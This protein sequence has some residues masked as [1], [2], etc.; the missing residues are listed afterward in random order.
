MRAKESDGSP[1]AIL[2]VYVYSTLKTYA[3]DDE[4]ELIIREV[5]TGKV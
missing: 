4:K 3:K 2:P 1:N 5:K